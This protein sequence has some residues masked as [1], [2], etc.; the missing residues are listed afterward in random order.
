MVKLIISLTLQ[1]TVSTPSRPASYTKVLGPA[2]ARVARALLGGHSLSIA[3]AVMQHDGIREAVVRVLLGK[4][5]EECTNLCRKTTPSHFHTIPV[6]QL[7]T[8]SWKDMV[9]DLQQK[10]PFV[11]TVLDSITSRNDHRNT[12][13]VGA[14]HY[15]GICS[16][17]AILLKER[18]REMCGLQSLV[19]LVMYS[20]H[21]EKQ[22]L[23]KFKENV[24][25][26]TFFHPSLTAMWYF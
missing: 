24:P 18:N 7:D 23:I 10:A 9:A 8:F 6:D 22:V 20:C 21:A 2:E 1:V 14:V 25:L 11:F 5:N 13:K 12:T 4:L 19:S 3:K 17:V 15:P 26:A 16:A